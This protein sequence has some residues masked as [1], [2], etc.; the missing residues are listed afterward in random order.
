MPGSRR[1]DSYKPESEVEEASR[2][3]LRGGVIGAAKVPL[4]QASIAA[5]VVSAFSLRGERGAR[6]G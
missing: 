2:E 4:L 1:P 5:W 6:S 3:A